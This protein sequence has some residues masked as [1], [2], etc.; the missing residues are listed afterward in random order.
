MNKILP[1]VGV[2]GLAVAISAT[3]VAQQK[4]KY[5]ADVPKSIRT[6]DVV[7]TKLLG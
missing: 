7:E 4:P 6:P 2:A 3:A 1:F 5:A